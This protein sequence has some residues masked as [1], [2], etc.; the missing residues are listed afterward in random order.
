MNMPGPILLCPSHTH[1]HD[2]DAVGPERLAAMLAMWWLS[3]LRMNLTCRAP[4]CSPC[5]PPAGPSG[6]RQTA[7]G[8]RQT[9]DGRRRHHS[10][11]SLRAACLAQPRTSC[12]P[13]SMHVLWQAPATPA[14][15]DHAIQPATYNG[16][17]ATFSPTAPSLATCSCCS[18]QRSKASCS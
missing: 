4:L 1:V 17:L 18:A 16:P 13:D 6:S 2:I 3:S 8:R 11:H 10:I 7:A 15:Q 14:L 9:A 5:T 12:V